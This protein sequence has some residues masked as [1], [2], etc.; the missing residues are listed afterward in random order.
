MPNIAPSKVRLHDVVQVRIKH[1]GWPAQGDEP[2]VEPFDQV[3]RGPVT[4]VD[5]AGFTVD[6]SHRVDFGLNMTI[7]LLSRP[8]A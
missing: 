8:G 4:A 5:E 7:E 3:F 1:P 6:D 2:A